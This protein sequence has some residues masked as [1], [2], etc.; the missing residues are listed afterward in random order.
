MSVVRGAPV[1]STTRRDRVRDHVRDPLYRHSYFLFASTGL[2]AAT[3]FAFWL[4]AARLSDPI[5][6]G[7]AAAVAAAI[8]LLTYLTSFGLPYGLL[9]YGNDDRGLS[10]IVNFSFLFTVATSV[11]AAMVFVAGAGWWAPELRSLLGGF[12]GVVFFA[13][14]NAGAALIVLLDSLSA[15]RRATHYA[16]FR[17]AVGGIGRLALLAAL[18]WFGARGIVFAAFVPLIVVGGVFALLPRLVYPGYSRR[19]LEVGPQLRR[20]VSFSFHTFPASLFGGAPPFVLPLIVLAIAGTTDT[21]F[22]YVSWSLVGVLLLVPTAISNVSL[23]EGT[24]HGPRGVARR[25]RLF[26]LT[27]TL[28]AAIV[29]ALAAYPILRLYGPEYADQ[30]ATTLRILAV[31]LVPWTFMAATYSML[32]GLNRHRAL[33]IATAV[34]LVSSLSLP[35]VMGLAYGLTGVAAGWTLGVTISAISA[36][37]AARL[38]GRTGR[39]QA[40]VGRS[41]EGGIA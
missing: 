4:I 38:D 9:R 3:G 14:A 16:V 30:G 21:A 34:F 1:M 29:L 24:R 10:S 11:A 25:G 20:F 12:T 8:V 27:L 40:P 33:T 28:P 35:I 5:A 23:S 2:W 19:E 32:R 18:V 22:F 15:A 39:L 37:A 41:A 31:S 17:A 7:R 6:V 13:A 26:A 36:E